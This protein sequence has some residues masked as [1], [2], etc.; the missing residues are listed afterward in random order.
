MPQMGRRHNMQGG[1]ALKYLCSDYSEDHGA[2]LV[3]NNLCY[4]VQ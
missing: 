2:Y 3:R 1:L 4:E